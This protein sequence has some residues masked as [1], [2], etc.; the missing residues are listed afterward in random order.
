M[1]ETGRWGHYLTNRRR[2]THGCTILLP[3]A[4]SRDVKASRHVQQQCSRDRVLSM[5]MHRGRERGTKRRAGGRQRSRAGRL[6]MRRSPLSPHPPPPHGSQ[7]LGMGMGRCIGG[8]QRSSA[9]RR[10][11]TNI[12]LCAELSS[13]GRV[14]RAGGQAGSRPTDWAGLSLGQ[15]LSGR[16][17]PG[18]WSR[19][20]GP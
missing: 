3:P 10:K 7:A 8:G 2:C 6:C 9:D 20:P 1:R 12:K 18:S 17:G 14:R 19:Q 15:L 4:A 13:V 16:S 5:G 11:P